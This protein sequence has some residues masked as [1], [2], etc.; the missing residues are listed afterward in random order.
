MVLKSERLTAGSVS[1]GVLKR[2][3]KCLAFWKGRNERE[4]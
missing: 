4:I 3:M 1:E 2:A